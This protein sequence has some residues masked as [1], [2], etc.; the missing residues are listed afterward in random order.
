M[1][2][3]RWCFKLG[4]DEGFE[5]PD[6]LTK[7]HPDTKTDKEL[8]EAIKASGAGAGQLAA[9]RLLWEN[10]SPFKISNPKD[11]YLDMQIE[12][13]YLKCEA[14]LQDKVTVIDNMKKKVSKLEEF[15]EQMDDFG[16]DEDP[17]EEEPIDDDEDPEAA[18]MRKKKRPGKYCEN[19][20]KHGFCN[21]RKAYLKTKDCKY[22]K[23][24]DHKCKHQWPNHPKDCP[25]GH[26]PMELDIIPR[27]STN[28]HA[29]AANEKRDPRKDEDAEDYA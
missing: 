26:G 28:P 24:T 16:S 10:T 2:K 12:D 4:L 9:I 14:Q 15:G 25:Y 27:E 17:M 21:A 3:A 5:L 22:K 6:E 18:K 19:L 8:A 1:I 13:A 29:E 20:R 11:I 7:C 23:D